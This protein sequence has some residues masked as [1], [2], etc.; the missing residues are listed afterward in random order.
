M[1]LHYTG[2]V[3]LYI[4]AVLFPGSPIELVSIA[5]IAVGTAVVFGVDE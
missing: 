5:L 4:G 1:K 2:Y 3:F